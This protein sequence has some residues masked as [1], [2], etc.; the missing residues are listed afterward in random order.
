MQGKTGLMNCSGACFPAILARRACNV[1]AY[2]SE[3]LAE[4]CLVEHTMPL[5]LGDPTAIQRSRED[6]ESYDH[7]IAVSGCGSACATRLLEAYGI[8]PWESHM[9]E[10][11]QVAG[12]TP[13]FETEAVEQMLADHLDDAVDL[14]LRIPPR[15]RTGRRSRGSR[16]VRHIRSPSAETQ[17]LHAAA[18][19]WSSRS[20]TGCHPCPDR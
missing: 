2:R 17:S 1:A 3:N 5:L 4:V 13:P 7:M 8:E 18:R 12:R 14:V 15:P 20:S 9:S 11:S 19:W 16:S 10:F 6:L